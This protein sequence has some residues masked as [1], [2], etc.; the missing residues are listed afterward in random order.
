MTDQH[1]A[2]LVVALNEIVKQLKEINE[3]LGTIAK[4]R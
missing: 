3:K 2:R 4:S 1:A